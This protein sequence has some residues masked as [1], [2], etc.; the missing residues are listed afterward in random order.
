[1]SAKKPVKKAF[2]V[3]VTDYG[4]PAYKDL[5]FCKNDVVALVK[6]LRRKGFDCQDWIDKPLAQVSP[7]GELKSFYADA[8]NAQDTVLFYFSGHG[9]EVA[10]EQ[11][12]RGKG[13]SSASLSRGLFEGNLLELSTVLE[14]L[15]DLPAQKIVIVDA[16]RLPEPGNGIAESV[17][18]G[19]RS[20]LA[21]LR[22]CAVIYASADGKESFATPE[23]KASRFT[24]SLIQEL[25]KYGRGVLSTV[26]SAIELVAAYKD[27]KSQTPWIY[28]S[29][30]DRPLDGFRIEET[31]L[32]GMNFPAHLGAA[33]N[34]DVWTVMSAS[35]AVAQ[36]KAGD[37]FKRARLPEA[38]S[39]G[40]RSYH[41]HPDSNRHAFVK[42]DGKAVHEA[43]VSPAAATWQATS[44]AVKKW[45][46]KGM[47]R[48]FGAWWS[49]S[50][51]YLVA[52]GK[53]KIERLGA[54]IWSTAS[55]K[56][57]REV[58]SGLPIDLEIN[59]A[60]WISDDKLLVA[61]AVNKTSSSNVFLLERTGGAWVAHF[62]WKSSESL[63]ITSMLVAKDKEHVYIGADD[64]SIAVGILSKSN[65]PQFLAREHPPSGFT[66]TAIMPWSDG[67]RHE[68]F[69]E[70]GVC[71]I[72][73]DEHTKILGLTYFD[74][75]AAFWDA[76]L[77]SYVK[78]FALSRGARRPRI[79]STGTG[80]FLCQDGEK[81]WVFKV[82]AN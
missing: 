54:A 1:M 4:D 31:K 74:G 25:K 39:K 28:A 9:I 75:T 81:G 76:E 7:N 34:G 26:E 59:S 65:Q 2:L 44:V 30:R 70:I 11:I 46:V 69:V 51:A 82:V 47:A 36:F 57:K 21:Q 55:P 78:F 58:I 6:V 77:R 13:V 15:S 71:S 38:L 12:L 56:K 67:S 40:M 10:G 3:G 8:K 80:S 52:F 33:G 64:G 18:K 48:V 19:R 61:G 14:E 68:D 37:F 49:P 72:A 79:V 32:N 17:Q 53:P 43:V 24:L 27:G 60:A 5:P 29:L 35:S 42:S 16:C 22:N 23:N 62:F 41:P 50:G 73:V 20:A 66:S 63:R 45:E